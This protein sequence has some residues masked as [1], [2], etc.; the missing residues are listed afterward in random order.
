MTPGQDVLERGGWSERGGGG[1]L[2]PPSSLGPPIIPALGGPK[3][4]NLK[5]SWH[6]SKIVAVS[7]KREE[8]GLWGSGGGGPPSSYGVRPF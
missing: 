5:Y 4:F 7:L 6:Q 1:W 3:N 8:G 2:G